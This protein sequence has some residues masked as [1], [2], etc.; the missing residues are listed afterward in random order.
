M[1]S[2][3]HDQ[4]FLIVAGGRYQAEYAAFRFVSF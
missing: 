1:F 2:A 4:C 3:V